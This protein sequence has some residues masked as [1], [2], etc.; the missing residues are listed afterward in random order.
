MGRK[1]HHLCIK[2]GQ[3]TIKKRVNKGPNCF[4]RFG[5]AS[6]YRVDF[7]TPYLYNP[8]QA[9]KKN[10][11][12]TDAVHIVKITSLR[13]LCLCLK[14]CDMYSQNTAW[15]CNGCVYKV[16]IFWEGHKILWNLHR[17]FVLCVGR[18]IL[19]WRFPLNFVAFSEYMNFGIKGSYLFQ[20][21]TI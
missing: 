8:R 12:T 15:N 2:K 6:R 10:R 20:T 19:Q 7:H 3:S 21:L 17:R 11:N 18:S 4:A 13:V 1:W 16:H 14:K 5:N 9:R